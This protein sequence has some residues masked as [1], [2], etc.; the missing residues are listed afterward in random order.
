M[1]LHPSIPTRQ[2]CFFS[3]IPKSGGTALQYHLRNLY[4]SHLICPAEWTAD[5]ASFS[6][7]QLSRYRLFCGHFDDSV[8]Q[9]LPDDLVSI[10][11]LRDPVARAISLV[12]FQRQLCSVD[13]AQYCG[14]SEFGK[15]IANPFVFKNLSLHAILNQ[16]N[17]NA[18]LAISNAM[19]RWLAG[20]EADGHIELTKQHLETAKANLKK[21]SI[22][23]LAEN[24]KGLLNTVCIALG[25]APR[26]DI[27]LN[28]T[29][30]AIEAVSAEEIAMLKEHNTLDAEL[31]KYAKLLLSETPPVSHY[32][33]TAETLILPRFHATL[34]DV[35]ILDGWWPW[36]PASDR[37]GHRWTG[38]NSPASIDIPVDKNQSLRITLWIAGCVDEDDL[39]VAKISADGKIKNAALVAE[40]AGN[41]LTASFDQTDLNKTTQMLRIELHLP[42][43]HQLS[44]GR[45]VGAAF[46]AITV[47]PP[48]TFPECEIYQIKSL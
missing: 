45:Q 18:Y 26:K 33:S 29:A 36:E 38:P 3:H 39:R 5:I 10:V 23:G 37:M 20:R 41:T 19:T 48:A 47:G 24:M 34:D 13:P 30:E 4:A 16:E 32:R 21:Y 46:S 14:T 40:A 31:I 15:Q 7:D 9:L 17:L 6:S 43:T 11:V 1:N 35:D 22:I 44:D 42:R 27:R 2:R 25:A 8:R 12:R 28:T